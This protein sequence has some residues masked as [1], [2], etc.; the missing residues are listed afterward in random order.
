MTHHND[1]QLASWLADGPH[2]GSVQV[3][4]DALA[5]VHSIRQRPGWLVSATGAT[6]A[7]E[8][9]S[10]TMRFI[11]LVATILVLTTLLVGAIV[12]GGLLPRPAPPVVVIAS[13][14]ASAAAPISPSPSAS[15]TAPPANGLVVFTMSK[16]LVPGEGN[17]TED[18]PQHRC[19]VARIWLA[20]ADGTDAHALHPDG[21]ENEGLLGW[22]PDGSGILTQ[23]PLTGDLVLI[24]PTGTELRRFTWNQLCASPCTGMDGF[25]FSPDG[26]QL[27]FVRSL[28]EDST[29]IAVL[30]LASGDVRDLAS[31]S[32]ANLGIDQCAASTQCEGFDSWPRWSPDGSR[33]AFDLQAMSPEP[34]SE[35]LSS[36]VFVVDADGANLERVTPTGLNA[37]VPTWSP[38]GSRLA[39]AVAEFVVNE[40]R[41]TVTA[42]LHDIYTMRTDGTDIQQLTRDGLSARPEWTRDGRIAFRRAA[43]VGIDE[44]HESWIMDADGSNSTR[45]QPTIAGMTAA[46][47]MTCNDSYWQPTR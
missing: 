37:T 10:G 5:R 33:I 23:E 20:N 11:V 34:G 31:T 32:T 22:S 14:D 25:S 2:H 27:A 36:A 21:T 26:T 3:R 9:S 13:P 6:L 44:P 29:V 28:Q 46:G 12:A 1:D 39:V 24:D 40:E 45:L 41:T 38:D 15:T 4:E 7:D 30:E 19:S 43:D 47:C 35:W 17:C 8:A 42:I 16:D 18:G